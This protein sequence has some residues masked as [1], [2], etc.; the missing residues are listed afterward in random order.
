MISVD[1]MFWEAASTQ[2]NTAI[3]IRVENLFKNS[4]M[5]IQCPV[6]FLVFGNDPSYQG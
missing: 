1:F 2:N 3:L 6:G 5:T 4:N